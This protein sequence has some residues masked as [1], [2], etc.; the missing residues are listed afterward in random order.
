M[1]RITVTIP[2]DLVALAR[3]DVGAGRAA[4]VSAWIVEA[5]Q[6]R[7]RA[8][9]NLAEVLDQMERDQ[10]TP[11]AVIDE[12]AKTLGRSRSWVVEQLGL[13]K[14]RRTRAG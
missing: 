14:P 3:S 12:I 10:P 13:P 1:Q 5:M 2:D 11:A 7:A 6:R 4:S 8:R 9:E